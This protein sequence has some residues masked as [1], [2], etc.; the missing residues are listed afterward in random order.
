MS[1]IVAVRAALIANAA[2]AALAGARV[3]PKVL[4]QKP[5]YPAIT[6][7]MI[8]GDTGNSLTAP[9]TMKWARV[10]LNAWGLTYAAAE[11]LALAAET[12]LNVTKS[13]QGA[14]EIRSINAQ[15]LRDFYEPAVEAHYH[16]QDYSIH[17]R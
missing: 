11:G 3:Y 12:A 5:T 13:T 7:E 6:L 8:S 4:P 9:G 15:G 17:Y 10:R 16:S 2:V 14:V 1:I